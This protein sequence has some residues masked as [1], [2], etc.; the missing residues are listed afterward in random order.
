MK[1][2]PKSKRTKRTKSRAHKSRPRLLIVTKVD[3][4]RRRVTLQTASP[5][6]EYLLPISEALNSIRPLKAPMT[7]ALGEVLLRLFRIA[8]LSKAKVTGIGSAPVASA[9][10]LARLA[11]EEVGHALRL[12][13]G[14]RQAGRV[15]FYD[16]NGINRCSTLVGLYQDAQILTGRVWQA[17][18]RRL[19]D[20]LLN[21]IQTRRDSLVAE[22]ELSNEVNGVKPL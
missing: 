11:V 14:S 3:R 15:I 4:R 7:Y 10:L 2:K 9:N 6:I 17:A 5:V 21:R 20:D 1:T 13:D 19:V 16:H 22:Q 8:F 12:Y 18:A